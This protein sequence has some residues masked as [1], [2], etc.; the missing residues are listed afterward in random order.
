MINDAGFVDALQLYTDLVQDKSVPQGVTETNFASSGTLFFQGKAAMWACL[1]YIGAFQTGLNAPADFPV[2][3]TLFP[4]Q[5]K[6]TGFAKPAASI[7]TPTAAVL[8]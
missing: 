7:L 5:P 4:R 1:S 2:G 6:P 8:I 3:S